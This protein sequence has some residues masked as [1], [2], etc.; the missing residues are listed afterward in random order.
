MWRG[1]FICLDFLRFSFWTGFFIRWNSPISRCLLWA[2]N[3]YSK[4]IMIKMTGIKEQVLL[5]DMRIAALNRSFIFI[6]EILILFLVMRFIPYDR[7]F[8]CYIS[9]NRIEYC[10]SHPKR[11]FNSH[12]NS[13]FR[14]IK[15][16]IIFIYILTVSPSRLLKCFIHT[17]MCS[18]WCNRCRSVKL[19]KR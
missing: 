2:E 1:V 8:F 7:G 10:R 3:T 9:T 15:W 18:E 11:N 13:K 14:R 5:L 16:E 19:K 12:K 17:I 4:S 6:Y